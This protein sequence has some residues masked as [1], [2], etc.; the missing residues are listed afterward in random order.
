MSCRNCTKK[1]P[2]QPPTQ[3]NPREKIRNLFRTKI[4]H[5]ILE[6]DKKERLG[7]VSNG[8]RTRSR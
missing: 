3:T 1:Q 7:G 5:K 6:N 8:I 2:R 4:R